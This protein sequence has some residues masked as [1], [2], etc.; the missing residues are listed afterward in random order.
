MR[1]AVIARLFQD[2]GRQ[3]LDAHHPFAAYGE[4]A[5]SEEQARKKGGGLRKLLSMGLRKEKVCVCVFVDGRVGGC[6][7]GW[8]G[9]RRVLGSVRLLRLL[10]HTH[11]CLLLPAT[12]KKVGSTSWLAAAPP[13]QPPAL[14]IARQFEQRKPSHLLLPRCQPSAPRRAR[15]QP[16]ATRGGDLRD[17]VRQLIEEA[18]RIPPPPPLPVDY[19][20]LLAELR[21]WVGELKAVKD[22]VQAALEVRAR[23]GQAADPRGLGHAARNRRAAPVD[24]DQAGRPRGACGHAGVQASRA[25][26]E[27][28]LPAPRQERGGMEGALAPAGAQLDHLRR[29]VAPCPTHSHPPTRLARWRITTRRRRPRSWQPPTQGI[30]RPTTGL[31]G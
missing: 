31:H 13:P 23:A 17:L 4:G 7:G 16:A 8:G 11:S 3:G 5:G 20:P 21:G 6:G 9:Q 26:Y 24:D 14:R 30:S 15:L 22:D 2:L 25:V 12:V 1:D 18:K 29:S 19:D 27:C 10:L 28:A